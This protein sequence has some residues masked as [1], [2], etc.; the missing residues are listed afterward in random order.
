ME[1]SVD[2]GQSFWRGK[3]VFVTGHTGFKGAWLS[4]WLSKLNAEV[5][6]FALPPSERHLLY[7]TLNLERKIKSVFGDITDTRALQDA[8]ISANPDI[9]LHLA[10][11]PL[12]QLSF[13]DPVDTFATNVM[14]TVN[15]LEAIRCCPSVKAAVIV[16]TDKCYQN[17]EWAWPYRET[18]KLGGDDPYSSS[19]ACAELVTHAYVTSYFSNG[20]SCERTC[21]IATARAGNV[22]GGGDFADDRLI[23][24]LVRSLANGSTLT[25]RNPNATRPW[26]F[27]LEPLQAYLLLA[28]K[29]YNEGQKYG[30][31]WNFGPR[32]EDAR[33]VE[34]VTKELCSRLNKT[35]GWDVQNK[36]YFPEKQLLR[37]DISKSEQLLGWSPSL[38]LEE[39]LRFTADWYANYLNG[40][41]LLSFTNDQIERFERLVSQKAASVNVR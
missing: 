14:G 4:F 19:K 11:Q 16:T 6:G 35:N 32:S 28:E 38:T 30:G 33:S 1:K 39:G 21:A 29:L 8:L 10:A 2:I 34:W 7:G 26:Q 25:L 40:S 12:V 36:G 18:D 9:V 27:V 15:I 23:P 20:Q 13:K 37:L 3:R 41:D 31:G 22:I 17:M 5:V 24:D